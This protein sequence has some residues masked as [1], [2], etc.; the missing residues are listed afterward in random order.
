MSIS[1]FFYS[2]RHE[3]T[4]TLLEDPRELVHWLERYARILFPDN[5]TEYWD[6]YPLIGRPEPIPA[7][8]DIHHVYAYAAAGGSEGVMVYFGLHLKGGGDHRVG[9]AKSFGSPSEAWEIA[10]AVSEALDSMIHFGEVPYLV[11]MAEQIADWQCTLLPRLN[12]EPIEL[13]FDHKTLSV[14]S[15]NG[16]RVYAVHDF[17][18]EPSANADLYLEALTKDWETVLR[19]LGVEWK[20]RVGRPLEVHPEM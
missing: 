5:G 15:I 19:A 10:R 8:L 9:F 11:W 4:D 3:G 16:E 6:A 13:F 12:I 18:H 14:R 17:E 7:P 20:V 2:V 1:Q